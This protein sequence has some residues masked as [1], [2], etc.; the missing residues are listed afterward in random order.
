MH[1]TPT[2]ARSAYARALAAAC[3][4]IGPA[5]EQAFAAVPREAFLPPPPW[6]MPSADGDE[7]TSDPD[8]L[9]RDRLVAIDPSRGLNN[10]APSLWAGVY[11]ALAI[12]PGQR[13]AHLGCG[14]GYYSAILAELV[15]TSGRVTAVEI[16]PSLAD[17]ARS[18]LRDWSHVE[19]RPG[20]AIDHPR[21]PVDVII[22]NAGATRIHAGWL[23]ALTPGGSLY[24]PLTSSPKDP[25]GEA[26]G[27]GIGPGVVLR[28]S[29]P[30]GI[31]ARTLDVV[32]IYPLVGARS[33]EEDA[34]IHRALSRGAE[35]ARRV[36]SYRTD[37]HPESPEC[38]LHLH[39]SCLSY[40]RLEGGSA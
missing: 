8:D 32:G 17:R 11:D 28:H 31:E 39:D 20:S 35:A 29:A 15:G 34:A 40:R 38:W 27:I 13:V 33:R 10:G 21:E 16:D 7:I 26:L 4:T 18:N 3:N 2:P 36:A 30:D 14:A 22:V 25:E 37:V 5:I 6:R 1:P 23:E 12:Q 9:H 19:V 24:V